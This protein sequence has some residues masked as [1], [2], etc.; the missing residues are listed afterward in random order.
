MPSL[1]IMDGGEDCGLHRTPLSRPSRCISCFTRIRR[2][3]CPRSTWLFG[4]RMQDGHAIK[5][6]VRRIC[7]CASSSKCQCFAR[8]VPLKHGDLDFQH[9]VQHYH[10]CVC[11]TLRSMRSSSTVRSCGVGTRTIFLQPSEQTQFSD[12]DGSHG[13]PVVTYG[14]NRWDRL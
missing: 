8:K 4:C 3:T 10:W 2:T 7:H 6:I 13:L 11:S 1:I 5:Q 12:R 14:H 9:V